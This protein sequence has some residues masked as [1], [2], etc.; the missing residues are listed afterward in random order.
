MIQKEKQQRRLNRKVQ[1]RKNRMRRERH[2][3]S[4]GSYRHNTGEWTTVSNIKEEGGLEDVVAQVLRTLTP[5]KPGQILSL[6]LAGCMT[7]SRLLNVCL[8]FFT[9][10]MGIPIV[11]MPQP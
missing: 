2:P 5:G 7:L 11:S 9:C 8:N 4:K 1:S 3:G 10:K 6:P